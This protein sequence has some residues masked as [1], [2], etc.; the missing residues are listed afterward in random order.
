M[1]YIDNAVDAVSIRRKAG[2][3]INAILDINVDIE[4]KKVAF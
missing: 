1:E 3:K 4:E 2:E